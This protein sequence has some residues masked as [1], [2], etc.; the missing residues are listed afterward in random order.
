M[1]SWALKADFRAGVSGFSFSL[2]VISQVQIPKYFT[3][4]LMTAFSR[5]N[6]SILVF[7]TKLVEIS[8][9]STDCLKNSTHNWGLFPSKKSQKKSAQIHSLLSWPKNHPGSLASLPT[10]TWFLAASTRLDP[11]LAFHHVNN[12]KSTVIKKTHGSWE[13]PRF[14]IPKKIRFTIHN[15]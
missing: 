14:F 15:R 2:L 1:K 11:G 10:L 9:T 3:W 6:S 7:H 5:Y 4:W 8:S 13:D 12:H